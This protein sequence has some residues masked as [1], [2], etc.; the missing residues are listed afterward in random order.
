M[1]QLDRFIEE[2]LDDGNYEMLWED[3]YLVY[4]MAY[5]LLVLRQ[6]NSSEQIEFL[7]FLKVSA[8][9]F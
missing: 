1:K 4:M 8:E 2:A 3:Y 9:S 7:E 6:D 5:A